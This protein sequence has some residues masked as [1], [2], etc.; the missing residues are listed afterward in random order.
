VPSGSSK[1]ASLDRGQLSLFMPRFLLILS[2]VFRNV[3]GAIHFHAVLLRVSVQPSDHTSPMVFFG[4]F[5]EC[6]S[7]IHLTHWG[8]GS[9]QQHG[10]IFAARTTQCGQAIPT[11]R[12]CTHP[13]S[14]QVTNE[15]CVIGFGRE[16]QQGCPVRPRRSR[17]LMRSKRMAG[18]ASPSRVKGV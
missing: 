17:S 9:Q 7:L 12:R 18:I 1:R 14:E 16:M 3:G 8:P 11:W 4:L 10:H 2:R 6:F 15:I 13:V 5:A